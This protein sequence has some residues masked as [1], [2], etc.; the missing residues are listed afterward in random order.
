M[1]LNSLD[2]TLNMYSLNDI[3][4]VLK[5]Y[6]EPDGIPDEVLAFVSNLTGISEDALWYMVDE[7]ERR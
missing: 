4:E 5:G 1:S 3:L 6:Q 2:R 7:T